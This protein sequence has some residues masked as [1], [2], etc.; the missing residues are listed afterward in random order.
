MT[1]ISE[2]TKS[3]YATPLE[4]ESIDDCIFYHTIEL[5]G[6]GVLNGQWDLR[7]GMEDYLGHVSF[8]GK[9]VLD[10][11]TANGI[12]CFAVEKHGAEVVGYDLSDSHE[13][14]IVPTNGVVDPA[15]IAE[16]KRSIRKINNAWWFSR[17]L[18]KSHAKMVYGTVYQIPEEIGPF[19]ISIVGN[20]LLHNRDPFLALQKAAA[21]TTE[22][23]I[24]TD[25]LV[26]LEES[27]GNFVIPRD[28]IFRPAISSDSFNWW[29]MT[30]QTVT[31]FLNV[32]GF[33]NCQ[34]SYH[35]QLYNG[36]YE[37]Q[38]TVVGRR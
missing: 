9:R 14:D 23:I 31:A 38:F 16:R 32:L 13:W 7:D 2:Y 12:L 4:V 36:K 18:L 15:I 25:L 5:P 11:G 37:D 35:R 10:V 3:P 17:R 27:P 24:V 6:Y 29:I 26:K 19:H 34:T 20:I 28:L 30:P 1:N 22:T 21:V 8:H 33:T